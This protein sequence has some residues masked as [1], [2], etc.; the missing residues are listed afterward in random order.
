MDYSLLVEFINSAAKT[1][2]ISQANDSPSSNN[3]RNCY[4]FPRVKE[5]YLEVNDCVL[6]QPSL[7]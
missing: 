5:E 3:I 1:F 7:P 2:S 4:L 6:Y